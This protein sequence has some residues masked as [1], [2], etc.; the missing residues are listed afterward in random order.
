MSDIET[1]IRN[2][3]HLRDIAETINNVELGR[4]ALNSIAALDR[5]AARIAELEADPW[6][7]DMGLLPEGWRLQLLQYNDNTIDSERFS[8]NI[9]RNDL[10]VD[11]LISVGRF[12]PT[13]RA[14]FAAACA[15]AREGA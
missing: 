14:A 13:P 1:I 7:L 2:L 8:V 3:R 15:R 4:D 12:G 11:G 6:R 5:L 10:T 9:G